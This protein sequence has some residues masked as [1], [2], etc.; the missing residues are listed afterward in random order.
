MF[1]W[2]LML[3]GTPVVQAHVLQ[4]ALCF[5][6]VSI[7]LITLFHG[8]PKITGGIEAWRNLGTFV[9]PLGI[10]FLPVMWGF[11][12]ACTQFFGGT[13]LA[14]GLATRLA[15]LALI[16]MMIVAVAWHLDRSDSYNVWSFP[17]SLIVVYAT[18]V[19]LGGGVYSVDYYLTR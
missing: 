10:Y 5:L 3:I 7:G 17:L 8:I 19:W 15:S 14:L 16:L 13:L 18:F 12:G 9:Q 2:L 11:L 4:A 1:H 6:R